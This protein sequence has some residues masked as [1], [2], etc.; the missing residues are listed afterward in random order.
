MG[1]DTPSGRI[2]CGQQLCHKLVGV[3]QFLNHIIVGAAAVAG[4]V[5]QSLS[6]GSCGNKSLQVDDG[7]DE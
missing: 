1:S 2:L 6:F 7:R 5:G 3:F 4:G